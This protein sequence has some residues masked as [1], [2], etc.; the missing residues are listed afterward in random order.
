MDNFDQ[1]NREK[2]QLRVFAPAHV[3]QRLQWKSLLF[4]RK[5]EIRL[6]E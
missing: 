2:K 3:S 1:A 6:D 4:I 5:N